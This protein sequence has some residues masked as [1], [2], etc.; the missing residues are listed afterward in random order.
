MDFGRL[1]SVDGV[2]FELPA[3]DPVVRDV[4]QGQRAPHAR[5]RIGTP[6][7]AD[8]G[9]AGTI[10]PARVRAADQLGLYARSFDCLE[11]NSTWY[12]YDRDL[13]ARWAAQVSEDF[14][15][16]AKLP[17]TITHEKRL[18]AC[19][20]E[21]QDFAHALE[22]LG[23]TLGL[24]WALLPPDFGPRE[25]D[26]LAA[27][28]GRVPFRLAVE[29]RHPAFFADTGARSAVFDL[30]EEHGVSAVLTDVAGR[31]DVLHMRITDPRALMLRFTGNGLHP[32][33]FTRLDA[34]IERIAAWID[35]GLQTLYVCLHQPQE[36]LNVE[37]AEYLAPRLA[38][39][40]GLE[41]PVP[42][43]AAQQRDLF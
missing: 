34:W 40:L 39:R 1:P 24:G 41:L 10:Y 11:L 36:A 22:A 30:F 14:R 18:V 23:P 26:D 35:A 5:V 6:R 37:V 2:D 28:I 20:A 4:L 17:A 31:R 21:I 13:L 16:L 29:L 42:V 32:S 27:F 25:L 12:G 15:F 33:D 3:D 43:R 8:P 38:A 19:D 7:F 9:F